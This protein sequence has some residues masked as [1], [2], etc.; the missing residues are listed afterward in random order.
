[1]NY[2]Q[3]FY[4]DIETAGKY[5]TLE[6]Y[7]IND[8]RGAELFELKYSQKRKSNDPR[9]GD[10]PDIAYLRNSPL[11]CEFGRIVSVGMA[12]IKPDNSISIDA[13]DGEDEKDILLRT[14]KIF[15][16]VEN[17]GLVI[18]GYNIK[19]FDIP[20][21][22]KKLCMYG[23]EVPNNLNTFGKK[24][25]EV[26]NVDIAEVWKSTNWESVPFGEVA[27]SLGISSPKSGEIEGKNVHKHYWE[28]K[29]IKGISEY[30]KKD[31]MTLVKIC[32]KLEKI[33]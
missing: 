22:F 29:N 27:Y 10:D 19:G 15:N 12:F 17:S 6:D 3:L 1:M 9:W 11:L 25:W 21:L 20:W 4:F 18:C 5:A 2:K 23:L 13:I 28:N 24:P 14:Q 32:E 33:L 31:V 30:C 16:K 26:K 8:S 7:Y